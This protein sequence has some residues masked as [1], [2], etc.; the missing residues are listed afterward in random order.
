M[1]LF[2][3][4]AAPFIAPHD[5]VRPNLADGSLP[6]AFAP[7]GRPDYLLGTDR[8][9]RDVLS[10][11][12]YGA[13]VS[14]AVAAATIV[15][16]GALGISLGLLAG[17]YSGGLGFLIA[18]AIDVSLA[19]PS[20]LIALV[21]AISIGPSFWVVV[22]VIA[23][24]VWPRYARVVRGE[25]LALKQR[26]F[27]SLAQ[28]AGSS[29]FRIIRVHILPNIANSLVVLSTLQVGWAIVTEG[30]LSFLGAG[31]PPPTPSWG[32]MVADGRLYVD[33]LWW[34]AAVPGAA[35]VLVVLSFNLFGD[36][37]RDEL[38]PQLRQL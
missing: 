38:D 9:G 31:I 35:I 12:I 19:F 37:L 18:S 34:I 20:I 21:L 33:T 36:W 5:P 28:I 14:L 23:F 3:A 24:Q 1:S 22:A 27:I 13:R 10:R 8:Q 29:P 30:F 17:Y 15:L 11:T 25:V 6:P 2:F 16:G 4:V 7:G 26:D 32:G